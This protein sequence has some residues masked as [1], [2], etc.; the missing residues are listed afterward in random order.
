MQVVII[1]IDNS[2][3]VLKRPGDSIFLWQKDALESSDH[4]A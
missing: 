4:R 2:Q 3:E 1:M